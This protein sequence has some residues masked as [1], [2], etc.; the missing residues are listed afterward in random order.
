MVYV[1]RQKHGKV[2]YLKIGHSVN[3]AKRIKG[4]QTSS[5]VPLT[6]LGLKNGMKKE[7]TDLHKMLSEFRM[8]GEWF[9]DCP[10]V[11]T[12]L[13][14]IDPEKFL[15]KRHYPMQ[16]VESYFYSNRYVAHDFDMLMSVLGYHDRFIENNKISGYSFRVG[17]FSMEEIP[18]RN[19]IGK[20]FT[21]RKNIIYAS[22]YWERQAM[23]YSK[24]IHEAVEGIEATL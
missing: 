18:D 19:Y 5:A 20:E 11:L 4:H 6:L 2:S 15:K 8:N 22:D 14:I 1:L 23:F 24:A 13:D 9:K 10:E 3:V 17:N 7:E 16:R 12:A 21:G